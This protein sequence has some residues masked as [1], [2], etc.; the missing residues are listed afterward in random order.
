MLADRLDWR[1]ILA[2]TIGARR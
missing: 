2:M 1:R